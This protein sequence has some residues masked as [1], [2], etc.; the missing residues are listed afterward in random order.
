MIIAL[1]QVPLQ[2]TKRLDDNLLNGLHLGL[3]GEHQ[4]VNAGL[5]IMLS[6]TWL[7]RTGHDE[8]KF[9]DQTVSSLDMEKHLFNMLIS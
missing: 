1:L 3:A 5:A 4:Y 6:S 7:Q 9:V 8:V 2:V